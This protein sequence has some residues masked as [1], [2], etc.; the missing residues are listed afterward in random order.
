MKKM[1][2]LTVAVILLATT[3]FAVEIGGVNLPDTLKAGDSTLVLNGAGLRKKLWIKVYAGGLYLTH[4]TNNQNQIINADEAM[5]VR[6]HFIHDGI[7]AKK[8]ISAWNEG[9]EAATGDNVA[10]IQ[11]K[12]DQ[13]NATF[14]VEVHE[15]D[16]YDIVYVPSEGVTVS[17]NG[18]KIDTISGLA[19]KKALFGIWL[20]DDPAD[21]GL[22][23]G[24]LNQ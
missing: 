8:L 22:K 4:K 6:M 14:K 13:F 24:M 21:S 3:A 12:I 19:F 11:M 10:P 1:I 18:K 17:F 2:L 15:G 7:A 5:A 20:C 9:F 16:F 23:E